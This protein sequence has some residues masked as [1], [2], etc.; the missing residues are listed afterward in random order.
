VRKVC[1]TYKKNYKTAMDE[2]M[3]PE[4][5]PLEESEIDKNYKHFLSKIEDNLN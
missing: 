3:K 5:L 4:K 2:V 1:D